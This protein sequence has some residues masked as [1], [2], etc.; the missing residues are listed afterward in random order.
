MLELCVNGSI[1]SP[2]KGLGPLQPCTS[3]ITP[4]AKAQ[5]PWLQMSGLEKT[6]EF[7]TGTILLWTH[8][9]DEKKTHLGITNDVATLVKHIK[10]DDWT[11]NL[12]AAKLRVAVNPYHTGSVGVPERGQGR[13][14]VPSQGE[15]VLLYILHSASKTTLRHYE[16]SKRINNFTPNSLIYKKMRSL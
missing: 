9:Q 7:Q 14:G 11:L 2:R 16:V 6:S 3:S 10:I 1:E 15:G 5:R 4:T 12:W 8:Q 13:V